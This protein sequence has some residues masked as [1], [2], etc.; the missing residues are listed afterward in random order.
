MLQDPWL[1]VT[2]IPSFANYLPLIAKLYIDDTLMKYRIPHEN[3][4]IPPNPLLINQT[5]NLLC[6]ATNVVTTSSDLTG[7]IREIW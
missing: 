1:S 5:V 7:P 3:L 4:L 6:M 2:F